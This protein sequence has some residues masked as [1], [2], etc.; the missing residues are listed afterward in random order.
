M[1]LT[2]AR[3]YGKGRVW[4]M[5]LARADPAAAGARPSVTADAVLDTALTLFAKRGHHGRH[6]MYDQ[7]GRDTTSSH[8]GP[9]WATF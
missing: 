4:I 2:S 8:G 6:A 5:S 1:I 9:D 7:P 3:S